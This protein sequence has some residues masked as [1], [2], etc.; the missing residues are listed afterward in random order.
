MEKMIAY[1]GLFCDQCPA[2]IATQKNDE[3]ELKK[4][5]E[6]WSKSSPDKPPL[7]PEDVLCDGCLATDGRIF[8]YC[9]TC[10]VRKCAIEKGMENC[11][12]CEEYA[13]DKLNK[14]L[15]MCPNAKKN[16]DEI[17]KDL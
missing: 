9:Q 1:C 8:N 17:R 4:V 13:C 3:V 11:A 5:A 2:F 7:K 14:F 6:E 10:E 15:E 16:L 12:H